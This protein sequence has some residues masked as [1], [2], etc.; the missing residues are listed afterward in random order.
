M[1]TFDLDH[2]DYSPTSS[3]GLSNQQPYVDPAPPSFRLFGHHIICPAALLRVGRDNPA[4]GR[5]SA[6]AAAAFRPR[7]IDVRA[8]ELAYPPFGSSQVTRT[9]GSTGGMRHA[10]LK[11]CRGVPS[12]GAPLGGVGD[13]LAYPGHL[14]MG[15]R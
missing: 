7:L 2:F 8:A 13:G 4:H 1:R 6:A 3:I 15:R 10:A 14:A 11:G 12:A 9:K 5:L